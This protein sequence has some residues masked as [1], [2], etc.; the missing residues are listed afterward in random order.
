MVLLSLKTKGTLLPGVPKH[1]QL[2]NAGRCLSAPKKVC[3]AN[4][5][6]EKLQT[7]QSSERIFNAAINHLEMKHVNALCGKPK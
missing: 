6:N 2:L 3:C 5:D 1:L 4:P 7:K